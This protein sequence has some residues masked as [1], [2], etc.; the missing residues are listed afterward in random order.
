MSLNNDSLG[1]L[2]E[3]TAYLTDKELPAPSI[4]EATVVVDGAPTTLPDD[5]VATAVQILSTHDVDI[6]VLTDELE[7]VQKFDDVAS[8]VLA[9][10]TISQQ[11]AVEIVKL[12]PEFA[13]KVG[14]PA[15]FTAA[16]SSVN[17]NQ[18]KVFLKK[19]L[20]EKTVSVLERHQKYFKD[21]FIQANGILDALSAT[22]V[23]ETIDDLEELRYQASDDLKLVAVTNKFLLYKRISYREEPIKPDEKMSLDDLRYTPLTCGYKPDWYYRKDDYPEL[24]SEDEVSQLSQLVHSEIFKRIVSELRFAKKTL[25]GIEEFIAYDHDEDNK[26]F[27]SYLGLLKVFVAGELET[28]LTDRLDALESKQPELESRVLRILELKPTDTIDLDGLTV[29][30][31]EVNHFYGQILTTEVVRSTLKQFAFL[32]KSIMSKFIKI[33]K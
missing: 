26:G 23:P 32:S 20:E 28:Y 22:L 33:A 27:C 9:Q 11:E 1:T 25:S 3:E 2:E 29:I 17:L 15:E 19:D 18:T 31:K 30:V 7:S 5:K 10:E 4:G 21:T 8:V 12:Q 13:E 24:P 16:P 14:A 6:K